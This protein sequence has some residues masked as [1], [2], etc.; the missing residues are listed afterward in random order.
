MAA[1]TELYLKRVK[2]YVGGPPGTASLVSTLRQI[3]GVMTT[4][5][6]SAVV[7]V[8]EDQ[9]PVG[10][11][12]EQDIVRRA[13]FSADADQP[14]NDIMSAPVETIGMEERLYVAITRMRRFGHRH[15]PVI[16]ADGRVCALIDRYEAMADATAE[17]MTGIDDL[18]R[19]GGIDGLREIKAAEA[20]LAS[21]LLAENVSAPEIQALLTHINADIHARIVAAELASLESEGWGPPPVPF[22]VIVLG[23]GGRGENA[24]HPD[25]DNGFILADYPDDRHSDIDA[26]FIELAERMTRNLDDIGLPF[27][28][29]H[30]MATNPLWRKSISQWRDQITHWSRRQ[31]PAMLLHCDIFFDFQSVWGDAVLTDELRGYTTQLIEGNQ[32]F[33]RSLYAADGDHATAR[34]WFHRFATERKNTEHKGEVNLKLGGLLPLVE[35]IR[36]LSLLAGIDKTST[37]SRMAEL[38][39][40]NILGS[41]EHDY[42]KG[43]F[44][45]IS[46]LLLRRQVADLSA[47]NEPSN[48]VPP[49]ALSERERDILSDSLKAVESLRKRIAFEFGGEIF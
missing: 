20:G 13:A 41:D 34:R 49:G 9:R 15:L 27:C 3:V 25:Q 32:G 12:T 16:D 44:E 33:L 35:C 47:G 39:A 8:D 18:T 23:S 11:V 28:R 19:G 31:K 4:D 10:I 29:G 14:V 42:L 30:V 36:L 24:L 5:K 40:R 37:L 45:H 1:S 48:F 2:D 26:W 43:A 46:F 22:S 38:A 21:K 17:L 7:I 6:L